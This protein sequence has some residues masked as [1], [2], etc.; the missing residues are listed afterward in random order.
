[1]GNNNSN[2]NTCVTSWGPEFHSISPEFPYLGKQN[3]ARNGK[4]CL[5]WNT[6][7]KAWDEYIKPKLG[8]EGY[9]DIGDGNHNYCRVIGGD[10]GGAKC[11]W[12]TGLWDWNYCQC[13]GEDYSSCSSSAQCDTNATCEGGKCRCNAGYVGKGGPGSCSEGECDLSMWKEG[14]YQL[15][16]RWPQHNYGGKLSVDRWGDECVSWKT[17]FDW[18]ATQSWFSGT[19]FQKE[20]YANTEGATHNYCRIYNSAL[21]V[22]IRPKRDDPSSYTTSLCRCPRPGLCKLACKILVM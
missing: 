8:E 18:A 4:T 12:G 5:K 6:I 7:G 10:T 15:R 20:I 16:D 11:Y 1:M 13:P 21:P 19:D 22:C 2:N 14:S 3:V 17:Y 9:I